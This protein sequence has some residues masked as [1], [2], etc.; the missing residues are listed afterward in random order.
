MLLARSSP[1]STPQRAPGRDVFY[2][3]L[4]AGY[5]FHLGIITPGFDAMRRLF[6]VVLPGS[7]FGHITTLRPPSCGSTPQTL[8]HRE[9]LAEAS[10]Q[11]S[12]H[13]C[14]CVVSSLPQDNILETGWERTSRRARR[15]QPVLGPGL[16]DG[17]EIGRPY[18]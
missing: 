12:F 11:L 10:R 7:T 14:T 6:F 16:H 15:Q 3:L 9:Y 17:F 2:N 4:Y 5:E 13:I 8:L 1:F 18:K